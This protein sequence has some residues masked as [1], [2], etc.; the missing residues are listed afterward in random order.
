MA[1]LIVGQGRGPSGF[2][3]IAPEAKVLPIRATHTGGRIDAT[4]VISD[5]IRY[6]TDHGAKVV[7]L[8]IAADADMDQCPA[9][10][11]SAI[12]DAIRHDVVIVA[13][14]GDEGDG[15]CLGG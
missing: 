13:G 10:V 1:A 5:V 15:A 2:A 12:A 4:R 11:A 14:A 6:A 7:N 9:P 3:G 8:S